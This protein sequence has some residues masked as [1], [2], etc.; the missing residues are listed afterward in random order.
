M[1]YFKFLIVLLGLAA[2]AL[3]HADASDIPASAT[4]Y[5]HADIDA[6]RDGKASRAV[7]DWLNAEVFEEIRGETGSICTKR[8]IV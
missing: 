4:W 6:M 8:R 1:R 3:A 5:F 7:Y 2:P